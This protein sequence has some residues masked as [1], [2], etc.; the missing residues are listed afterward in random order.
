M[1]MKEALSTG[2]IGLA[3]SGGAAR[4]WAHVGVLRAFR[5]A[6][7]NI[8]YVAGTSIGAFTGAFFCVDKLGI[9][10]DMAMTF[11]KR[12][13]LGFFDLSWSKRGIVAG[14]KVSEFLRRSFGNAMIEDMI[15]PF[16][17]VAADVRTGERLV[18]RSGSLT[19]AVR[20]SISI[21][22]LFEPVRVDHRLLIDGGLADPMPVEAVRK[23]GADKVVGVD[24]NWQTCLYTQEEVAC[25][26]KTAVGVRKRKLPF[27]GKGPGKRRIPNMWEV[28][29]AGNMIAQKHLTESRLRVDPCDYLIRPEVA[30]ISTFDFNKSESG[31]EAGYEA[32]KR[33]LD[34]SADYE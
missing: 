24:L 19:Q 12:K 16:A 25:R 30:S 14:R 20:A 32:A 33:F 23:M 17:A 28:A 1:K 5:E 26:R 22:G 10:E 3:L 21:P 11:G 31:I 7:I 29:V 2:K 18:L 4:G 9:L 6:D 15:L 8:D 27:G 34:E 13:A